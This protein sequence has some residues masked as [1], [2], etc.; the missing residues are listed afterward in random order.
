VLKKKNNTLLDAKYYS[1]FFIEYLN[2]T[3]SENIYDDI[4]DEYNFGNKNRIRFSDKSFNTTLQKEFISTSWKD[5]DISIVANSSLKWNEDRGEAIEYGNLIH[6]ILANIKTASDV[7]NS[8]KKHLLHGG[9]NEIEAQQIREI[10]SQVVNHPEL[11]E[12][13]QENLEVFNEY[14]IVKKDK[15]ILI[16]DRIIYN[17]D[18]VVI[19]DYKTGKYIDSHISQINGYAEVLS[20]MKYKIDKKILIYIDKDVVVKQVE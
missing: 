5:I 6:E 9:I 14:E 2:Q 1:D 20:E 12:Y 15:T 7:D 10:I 16:P 18:S 3:E 4:K 19:L 17:G 8:I 11:Q 13:F